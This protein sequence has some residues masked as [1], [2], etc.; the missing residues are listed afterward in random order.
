MHGLASIGSCG[1]GGYAAQLAAEAA[2]S[3]PRA[4]VL[5]QQPDWLALMPDIETTGDMHVLRDV[6]GSS[7]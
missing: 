5:A 1:L 6:Y 4:V 7:A 3:L 2:K